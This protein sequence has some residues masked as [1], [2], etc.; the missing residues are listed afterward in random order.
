MIGASYLYRADSNPNSWARDEAEARRRRRED[1][2]DVVFGVNYAGVELLRKSGA[3]T[4]SEAEELE[5]GKIIVATGGSLGSN[6][7]T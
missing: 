2:K 1:G 6:K 4:V 5:A 7:A 3:V